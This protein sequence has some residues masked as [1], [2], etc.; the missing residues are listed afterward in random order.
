[1]QDFDGDIY[2]LL[3][4]N[5]FVSIFGDGRW[6]TYTERSRLSR[7]R[8]GEILVDEVPVYHSG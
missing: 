1:M 5:C 7:C 6:C 8:M 4:A 2:M 3:Y